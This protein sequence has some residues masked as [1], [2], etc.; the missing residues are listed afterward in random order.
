MITA[1]ADDVAADGLNI[2]A[3]SERPAPNVGGVAKD[4]V[5]TTAARAHLPCVGYMP[6]RSARHLLPGLVPA[7]TRIDVHD[8]EGVGDEP[9]VKP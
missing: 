8:D 3:L 2:D 5:F 1:G 4:D 6:R 9:V 7:M